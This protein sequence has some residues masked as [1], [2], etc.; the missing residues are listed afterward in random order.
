M[1]VILNSST[2][3]NAT[4]PSDIS[5]T[6][7]ADNLLEIPL[8]MDPSSYN[9][10]NQRFNIKEILLEKDVDLFKDR[11]RVFNAPDG[12]TVQKYINGVWTAV[13]IGGYFDIVIDDKVIGAALAGSPTPDATVDP[14]TGLFEIFSSDNLDETSSKTTISYN[15]TV[16]QEI[17]VGQKITL[18]TANL[19]ATSNIDIHFGTTGFIIYNNQVILAHPNQTVRLLCADKQLFDKIAIDLTSVDYEVNS[20]DDTTIISINEYE[21][22][23][24]EY[25]TTVIIA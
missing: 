14:Y 10:L 12:F 22:Q 16:I 24:N 15:N 5:K 6:W 1:I 17:A 8:Y 3:V 9:H 21:T 2:H 11:V 20:L 23:A 13:E 4:P 19:K 25:G 7:I 18:A